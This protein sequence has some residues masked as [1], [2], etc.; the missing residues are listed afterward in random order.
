MSAVVSCPFEIGTCSRKIVLFDPLS[1]I[2]LRL[3]WKIYLCMQTNH[4]LTLQIACSIN[5]ILYT[6]YKLVIVVLFTL[7]CIIFIAW[8]SSCILHVYKYASN[9]IQSHVSPVHCYTL[10]AKSVFTSYVLNTLTKHPQMQ[11]CGCEFIVIQI[12]G[13]LVCH[14][15]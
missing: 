11:F 8:D 6:T 7:V 4:V 14:R 9:F 12:F 2:F 5:S 15:Q 13:K 3:I 1:A 10:N